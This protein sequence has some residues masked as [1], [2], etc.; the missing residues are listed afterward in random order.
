MKRLCKSV[1]IFFVM[2]M[3]LLTA[4]SKHPPQA[5]D[6]DAG[7]YPV[8]IAP[9]ATAR[10]PVDTPPPTPVPTPVPS[11]S[12]TP[13][14]TP[15]SMIWLSD[16]QTLAY[17]YP[18]PLDAMG[19]WIAQNIEKENIRYVLQ[20]GD[21]VENGYAPR[22]WANFDLCYNQFRDLLPYF[23][24]AGNHDLAINHNDYAAYL[25]RPFF[26]AYPKENLF[27]DG[28]ALFAEVHDGGMKLLLVGAGW[29]AEEAAVGWMSD[30]IAARPDYTVILLFH[31]YINSRGGFTVVGKKM[32]E[33]LVV[34]HPNV[35]LILC[36]HCS[37][38]SGR[39]IEEIDDDGDGEPD[40]SVYALMYNYQDEYLPNSGQLRILRIDP[41]L[42]SLTITTY[43][44]Y[45]KRYY[46]DKDFRAETFTLDELFLEPDP[47]ADQP[48]YAEVE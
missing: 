1:F 21:L 37:G 19:K 6:A 8:V 11:P 34:P 32:F 14:P 40:R 29:E 44:P 36:G 42:R 46:R 27:E 10:L 24:V 28:K 3:V 18:D 26:A 9:A 22:H 15:F 31:G 39:R 2:S 17:Q 20:T 7:A 5:G 48:R 23:P 35:K 25:E 45:S 16:T 30:V 33:Q 4:C 38:T 47:A 13:V 12:P 41:L 43:S